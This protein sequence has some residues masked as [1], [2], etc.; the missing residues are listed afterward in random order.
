MKPIEVGG[1]W[2]LNTNK[3]RH[4]MLVDWLIE[5]TTLDCKSKTMR[6]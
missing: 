5:T 2:G 1:V 4:T 6:S 3:K